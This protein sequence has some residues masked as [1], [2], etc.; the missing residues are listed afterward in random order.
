M[1][2]VYLLTPLALLCSASLAE[3]PAELPP[4]PMSDEEEIEFGGEPVPLRTFHT[5]IRP[6]DYFHF[7]H[8]M[9]LVAT[10]NQPAPVVL[11]RH[12]GATW[13]DSRVT[14]LMSYL[15]AV[16]AHYGVVGARTKLYKKSGGHSLPPMVT[17]QEHWAVEGPTLDEIIAE[18]G[19]A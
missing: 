17:D 4:P 1:R 18:F 5:S 8:Q 9:A 16:I 2:A 3:A 13:T 10:G 14:D 12:G 11:G 19:D 6:F 7:D 15:E